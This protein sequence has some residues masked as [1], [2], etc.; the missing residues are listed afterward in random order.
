MGPTNTH[1]ESIWSRVLELVKQEIDAVMYTQFVVETSLVNL[2]D[3]KA[4]VITKTDI[5]VALLSTHYAGIFNKAIQK[6]TETNYSVLFLTNE[7]Y[8]TNVK[9]EEKTKN[10]FAEI[11]F[12]TNLK[13]DKT[14]DN[15]IVGPA[16]NE[17]YSAAVAVA[18][19]PGNA[20]NPL[21]IWGDTGLGKTHLLNAIGNKVKQTIPNQRIKL[22][23]SKEF[24]DNY[25][26]AIN[27]NTVF[28]FENTLM[29]LDLLLIDD[30]QFF[31]AKH[32]T[33]D[34]FFNIFNNLIQNRKQVVITSDKHPEELR[35]LEERLVSRF[36]SGMTTTISC[37]TVELAKVIID[38]KIK[39][40]NFDP[41]I[42]FT[43]EALFYIAENNHTDVRGI[44]GALTKIMFNLCLFKTDII[45]INFVIQVF[46]DD[47]KN[48]NRKLNTTKIKNEVAAYFGI[49]AKKLEGNSRV[50]KVATAR[51]I[52]IY[53]TRKYTQLSFPMIGQEF[54]GRHHS[55]IMSSVDKI[56]NELTTDE[57]TIKT[58]SNLKNRLGIV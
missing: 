50:Q 32:Q 48:S 20:F 10:A 21:F 16:N 44:E 45:D 38:S 26:K 56:E 9:V 43:E 22:M 5:Q 2:E 8:L 34:T 55:T 41:N 7:S 58:I 36:K 6:V 14:F 40:M 13:D 18:N 28:D 29:N 37:P 1:Y 57:L 52:A 47:N 23:T 42:T 25:L 33:G 46:K 17:S 35:G 31:A 39:S 24:L 27:T 4:Y 51:H 54:G 11:S 12:T 49:D 15:F 3:G 53:L 19:L 30:I